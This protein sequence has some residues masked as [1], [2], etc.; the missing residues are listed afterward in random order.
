MG[1]AALVMNKGTWTC[2]RSRCAFVAHLGFQL[3]NHLL[4][5]LEDFQRRESSQDFKRRKLDLKLQVFP[6]CIFQ[7]DVQ[8]LQLRKMSAFFHLRRGLDEHVLAEDLK[9]LL[10]DNLHRHSPCQG[11]LNGVPAQLVSHQGLC[12]EETE[13]LQLL[14]ECFHRV[15]KVSIVL[16]QTPGRD[17]ASSIQLVQEYVFCCSLPKDSSVHL[18]KPVR[19]L[20]QSIIHSRDDKHDLPQ[21]LLNLGPNTAPCFRP[22]RGGWGG[23]L[24]PW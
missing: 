1:K 16:H 5:D 2:S 9:V 21:R 4:R 13:H 6:S 22:D 14:R 19:D 3:L 7:N 17:D 11:R 23:K 8:V 24:F 15:A 10:A 12:L 20:S 18:R